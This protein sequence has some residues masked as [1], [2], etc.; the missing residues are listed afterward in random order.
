MVL[1]PSL[2]KLK[3]KPVLVLLMNRML[4]PLLLDLLVLSPRA[5]ITF[6]L[7]LLPL[8]MSS[9]M[10]PLVKY[11]LMDLSPRSVSS[12]LL[13]DHLELLVLMEHSS[14]LDKLKLKPVLVLLM[15]RMLMLLLLD[16]LVLSPRAEITFS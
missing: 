3:L 11:G 1:S 14:S 9:W 15:N 13:L 8:A 10:D 16:L 2:D 5:E 12:A 4:M 6:S 7:M